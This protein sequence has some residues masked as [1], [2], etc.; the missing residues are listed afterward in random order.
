MVSMDYGQVE[1]LSSFRPRGCWCRGLDVGLSQIARDKSLTVVAIH[2]LLAPVVEAYFGHLSHRASRLVL[3]IVGCLTVGH[4]RLMTI[5]MLTRV[6]ASIIAP[7]AHDAVAAA[8][9]FCPG[10]HV[11]NSGIHHCWPN[12]R[13]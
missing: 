11:A 7:I 12:R 1:Q 6:A 3:T 10:S 4:P 5:L 9:S 2:P 8:R 13:N